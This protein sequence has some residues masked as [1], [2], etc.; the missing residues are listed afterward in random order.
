MLLRDDTALIFSVS[1][2]IS[3][4]LHTAIFENFKIYDSSLVFIIHCL[5]I[6]HRQIALERV[7]KNFHRVRKTIEVKVG[8]KS[9]TTEISNFCHNTRVFIGLYFVAIFSIKTNI[10]LYR[11]KCQK[12]T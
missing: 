9:V 6:F 8:H 11:A 2:I 1:P 12:T 10:Y 5:V 3:G 4:N 7:G